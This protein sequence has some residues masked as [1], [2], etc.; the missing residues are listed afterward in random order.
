MY[1]KVDKRYPVAIQSGT[2]DVPNDGK[3]HVV[4]NGDIV[5]STAVLEY[6]ELR[7]AELRESHR[8]AAG[9]PDPAEILARERAHKEMRALRA[10][11]VN[12]QERRNRGKGPGGRS[13]V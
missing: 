8:V 9:H 12:S 4:D 11:G 5:L 10:E 1:K 7:Y 3:Y 6:A 2:A 13:G